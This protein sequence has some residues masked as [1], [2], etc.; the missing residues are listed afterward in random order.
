MIITRTP[1]RI[2][3]V[4]GGSDLPA[5]FQNYGPGKVIGSTINKYVY[6]SLNRPFEDHVLAHYRRTER[7]RN[8]RFLLHDRMRECLMH[9]GN[10]YRERIEVASIADVPGNSGLGSSSAFT[11]GLLHALDVMHTNYSNDQLEE[12]TSFMSWRTN[13]AR[14]AC[15]IEQEN[16]GER[17]GCQDQHMTAQGGFREFHFAADGLVAHANFEYDAMGFWHHIMLLR[18]PEYED[19]NADAV[20]S[21][22]KMSGE[23]QAVLHW[24]SC[25]VEPFR[26]AVL[27]EDWIT[28]GDILHEAWG[29]KR[30]LAG[31]TNP[32]IDDYYN[33]ARELG[34]WGG[35]VCGAGQGGFLMLF[36]PLEI[37][38]RTQKVLGLQEL[39]F[40][41]EKEGTTLI[42][43]D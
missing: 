12:R 13:L 32:T 1:L 31:V 20:L 40:L 4:G 38:Q 15:Q 16:C 36:A 24:L 3:F 22:V 10:E 26:N 28:C 30:K 9:Y 39:E 43:H 18:L 17:I 42:Y 2:S 34:V 41:H 19:R 37:L 14:K 35:K 23:T 27:S 33:K 5:Y 21:G 25:A 6:V 29:M 11:V 7:V 8:V